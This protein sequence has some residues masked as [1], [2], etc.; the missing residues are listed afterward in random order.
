[1]PESIGK[2]IDDLPTAIDGGKSDVGASD[3]GARPVG[4]SSG[5]PEILYGFDAIEPETIRVT[6][7]AGRRNNSG[8]STAGARRGRPRKSDSE[9]TP[10][11][12]ASLVDLNGLLLSLHQMGSALLEIKELELDE[13]EAKKLADG[14]KQVT[15]FYPVNIDPKKIAWLNLG[16]VMTEIYGTRI[17]AYNMRVKAEREKNPKPAA[18]PKVTTM[19]PAAAGGSG[20]SNGLPAMMTPSDLWNEAPHDSPSF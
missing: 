1:M 9:K 11:I 7:G 20:G 2:F 19:R 5:E 8:G 10:E 18:V 13:T 6:A 3:S 15:K 17:M 14:I 4:G 12:P 16:I